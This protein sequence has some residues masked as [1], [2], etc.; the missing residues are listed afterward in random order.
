M[1]KRKLIEKVAIE[2]T[3]ELTDKGKLVEAGFAAFRHLMI[4]KDAPPLQVS[5]MRLA[6]MAGADH[7]FASIMSIMD[8]GEEPTDRDL[9]RMD[10]IHRELEEWRGKFFDRVHPQQGQA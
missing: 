10:L 9:A 2:V 1:S 7:L 5:E 4:A 8:P 3:K 6:F